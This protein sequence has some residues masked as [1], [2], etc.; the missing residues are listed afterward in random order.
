[1]QYKTYLKKIKKLPIQVLFDAA[2]GISDKLE[3][4]MGAEGH[5]ETPEFKQLALELHLIDSVIR[6]KQKSHKNKQ[7][8]KKKNVKRK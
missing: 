1:M 8:N 2:N 6:E 4:I 3:G 7:L 5:E